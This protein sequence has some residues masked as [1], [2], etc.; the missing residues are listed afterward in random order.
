MKK[1]VVALL[2]LICCSALLSASDEV[3]FEEGYIKEG[4]ALHE[5]GEYSEAIKLYDKVLKQNPKNEFALYEKAYSLVY[6]G[7]NRAAMRIARKL[8]KSDDD[9]ITELAYTMYGNILDDMGR[10]SKSVK[11]Y[12][13]ALLIFPENYLLNYNL[14]V[15]YAAQGDYKRCRRYLL[16]SLNY[17]PVHLNSIYSLTLIDSELENRLGTVVASLFFLFYSEKSDKRGQ[18]VRE[19]L[20]KL[21]QE[22][23]KREVKMKLTDDVAMELATNFT[24]QA[25]VLDIIKN[26]PEE[27]GSLLRVVTAELLKIYAEQ[28]DGETA[29]DELPPWQ[30]DCLKIIKHINDGELTE[31]FLD[32]IAGKEVEKE[33]LQAMYDIVTAFYR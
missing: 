10:Y 31:S 6:L 26:R 30:V 18:V 7:K 2:L 32:K 4:I 17:Y 20:L 21:Y 33:K 9:K 22:A 23:E 3:I 8:T 1:T 15:S 24:M 27:K 16:E 19:N 11:V 28:A 14:A 5:K 25:A 29:D 12:Y 13:E